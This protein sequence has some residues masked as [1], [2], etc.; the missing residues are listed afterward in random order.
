MSST[1]FTK[2]KEFTPSDITYKPPTVNKRG[3]K[4]VQVQLNSQP[5]VL[6]IP[7]MLTWG[8]NERV[9][10]DSGRVSYDIALQ[11]DPDASKSIS[12]FLDAMKELEEKIRTDAVKNSKQWFGKSK[13]TRVVIN[14][15][16]YP[17]LK[18]PKDKDTGEPDLS[19]NPT[20]KLKVPYWEE[21]FNVELYDMD[22]NVLYTP[23]RKGAMKNSDEV[24]LTPMDHLPKGAHIK[25]LIQC[26]GLWFAGGK[27]GVT[28]KLV[29]AMVNKP[30]RLVGSGKCQI[31]DDSD[32]EELGNALN[33]Q[34]KQTESVTKVEESAEED[35]DSGPTFP[36]DDEEEE[37]KP[38]TPPPAPKK[39]KKVV[40]RKKT[41]N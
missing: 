31:A 2:A 5:L 17:I 11:F 28:W 26:T 9:D 10:E 41:T 33:Q 3:G 30:V 29:Q 24:V 21:K 13:M 7:L 36:T 8:L 39:K 15:L 14:V 37:E 18:Y 38:L 19:R 1:T 25:G 27:W 12:A 34:T 35:E 40:R 22:R 32:D 23:P 6:Q 4:N 20:L 16:M